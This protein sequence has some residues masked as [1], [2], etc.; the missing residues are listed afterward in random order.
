M[1]G[2]GATGQT[3]ACVVA[4]HGP[5][6][7]D[8]DREEDGRDGIPGELRPSGPAQR[9]TPPWSDESPCLEDVE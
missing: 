1:R 7:A 6:D 9:D 8:G 2:R 3:V 4:N 5:A